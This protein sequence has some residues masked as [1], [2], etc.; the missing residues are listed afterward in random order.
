M[1]VFILSDFSPH[2]KL[3]LKSKFT[4]LFFCDNIFNCKP[5]QTVF[6]RH[7]AEKIWNKLTRGNYDIYLL[8]VASYVVK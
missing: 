6:G 1:C 2:T 7:V 4:L 5:I 8:S 3:C